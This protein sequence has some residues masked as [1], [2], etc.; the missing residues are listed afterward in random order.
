MYSSSSHFG[1]GISPI[2]KLLRYESVRRKYGM[3]LAAALQIQALT[4][5][6]HEHY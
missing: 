4:D 5:A 3:S 1:K 2:I 6:G